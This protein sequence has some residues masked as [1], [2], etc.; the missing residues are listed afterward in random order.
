MDGVTVQDLQ[1]LWD[2]TDGPCVSLFIALRRPGTAAQGDALRLKNLARQ[3]Q[4][5]LAAWGLREVD[6]REHMAAVDALMADAQFWKGPGRGLAVYCAPGL[7]RALRVGRALAERAVVSAR[8]Y[9]RPLLPCLDDNAPFHVLAVSLNHVRLLR[10]TA[11][12]VEPVALPDAPRS[13]DDFLAYEERQKDFQYRAGGQGGSVRGGGPLEYRVDERQR[14][15]RALDRAVASRLGNEGMLLVLAGVR[16]VLAQYREVNTHPRL[17][18]V[19]LTGSPDHTSPE[20]LCERALEVLRALRE[21]ER[22]EA[23]ARYRSLAG[24]GLTAAALAHVLAAAAG[25]RV[26]TLFL[27]PAIDRWGRHGAADGTAAGGT[28]TDS[29]APVPRPQPE[30]GDEELLDCAARHTLRT[31]GRVRAMPEDLRTAAEI[32]DGLAAILRY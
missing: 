20:S 8:C 23:V 1:S 29:G 16:N 25:G 10:A 27:D 32:G 21:A 9:T 6:A 4:E 11:L 15:L 5:R 13:L 7:F 18:S 31:G 28:A 17:V 24:T 30:P 22:G 2:H 19:S 14:Y 26:E 3:S 12:A